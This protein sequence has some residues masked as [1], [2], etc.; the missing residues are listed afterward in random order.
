M[1]KE[2]NMQNTIVH[3]AFELKDSVVL[4][5]LITRLINTDTCYARTILIHIDVY[6][7]RP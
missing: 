2:T 5:K 7:A 1:E 4:F 3:V 6:E